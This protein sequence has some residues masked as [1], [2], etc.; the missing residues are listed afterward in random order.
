[1]P[2]TILIT[3]IL[4]LLVG[5]FFGWHQRGQAQVDST[6]GL[7]NKKAFN[8]ALAVAAESAADG[9]TL[10]I[11]FLDVDHFKQVNDRFG[12]LAGDHLLEVIGQQFEALLPGKCYRWGGDE[13]TSLLPMEMDD[14][15]QLAES[16]RGS[17]EQ[18]KV[19]YQGD[20]IRATVSIGLAAMEADELES[21]S[22]LPTADAALYRAKSMGGNLICFGPSQAEAGGQ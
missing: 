9:E 10:V 17:I 3:A 12:H 7:L 1:M 2:S 18:A 20:E 4:F 13:F 16:L 19:H 21:R 8:E 11:C 14:A 22:A 15:C 5:Y 6:T